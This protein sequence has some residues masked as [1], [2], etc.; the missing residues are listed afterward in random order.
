MLPY[1]P[2]LSNNYFSVYHY[3]VFVNCDVLWLNEDSDSDSESD[4]M[5]SPV[6]YMVACPPNI[7]EKLMLHMI[8]IQ[9][10]R[11]KS[12]CTAAF[13]KVEAEG[14]D[15]GRKPQRLSLMY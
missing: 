11:Y 8:G 5:I 3:C 4:S 14:E 10:Y 6:A 9:D 13:S 15:I 2:S 1:L 7:R 12:R